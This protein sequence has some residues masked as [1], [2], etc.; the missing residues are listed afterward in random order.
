MKNQKGEEK[1]TVKSKFLCVI[2]RKKSFLVWKLFV[3]LEWKLK[4]SVV[5]LSEP[6]LGKVEIIL[7]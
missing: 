1:L 2:C 7:N 5:T 3:Y 4:F 6:P